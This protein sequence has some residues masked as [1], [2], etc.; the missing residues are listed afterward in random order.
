MDWNYRHTPPRVLSKVAAILTP[1][2][3][4]R[5]EGDSPSL[6]CLPVKHVPPLA[7]PRHHCTSAFVSFLRIL[8]SSEVLPLALFS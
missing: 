2:D 7:C 8:Q 4:D 5:L 6:L 3:S 1:P